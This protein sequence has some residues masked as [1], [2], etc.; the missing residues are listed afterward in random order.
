MLNTKT[1]WCIGLLSIALLLLS[2]CNLGG[3]NAPPEPLEGGTATP[4]L[5]IDTGATLEPAVPLEDTSGDS[6]VVVLTN[7]PIVLL[8]ATVTPN[9]A[10]LPAETLGPISMDGIEHHNK[11]PV[12]VRVRYGKSVSQINCSWALQ[13]SASSNVLSNPASTQIDDNTFENVYI[14]TPDVDGTY[15][16][17]CSAAVTRAN[18]NVEGIND[19]GDPFEVKSKG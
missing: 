13:G 4:T 2:A 3:T 8:D 7:T 16:V 6:A 5:V 19:I 1:I 14:F 11:E 10:A 9:P 17:S 12:T 15:V 18:G